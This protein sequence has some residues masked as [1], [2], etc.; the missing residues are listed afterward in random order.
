VREL[1]A[2]YPAVETHARQ[3][4]AADEAAVKG[5]IDEAVERYGRLDVMFANAGVVGANVLFTEVTADGFMDVMRTNA[6]R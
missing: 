4:D 6:L 3:F 1:K 5:V 2:L